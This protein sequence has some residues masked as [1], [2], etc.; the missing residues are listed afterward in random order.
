MKNFLLQ[1]GKRPEGRITVNLPASK[2]ISNRLQI[3]NR[4]SNGS[5]K[6]ENLSDAEDTVLLQKALL[7][8]SGE[9]FMGDAGTAMRFGLA[10]A[11]I[12][13]GERIL[14][15][16]KRL[17][18]RPLRQLAEALQELGADIEYL[19]KEGFPPIRVNGKSLKGGTVNMDASVSSQFISALML[20]APY[21][22]TGLE[23]HLSEKRVSKPYV[24]MTAQLMREAGAEVMISGDSI[25]IPAGEYRPCIIEVEPDWTAA[26]YFYSVVAVNPGMEVFCPG[27]MKENIQG[28][29]VL[30]DLYRGF[31][32]ETVFR[33]SGA[34]LHR[35]GPPDDD[36]TEYDFTRVPDIAQTAAVTAAALQKKFTLLGL[37]TLRLKETDRIWALTSQLVKCGVHSRSVMEALDLEAYSPVPGDGPPRI[38][39]FGD[40]R[41]AMS[42]APFVFRY[43]EL[44]IE[45]PEVVAKSF[46]GFWEEFRKTGVNTLE[47]D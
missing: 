10:W 32:V 43:G 42:F 3:M 18:K 17:N 9:L 7:E 37:D 40:H 13:P 20:V 35:I 8:K 41:M 44:I 23:I 12:T 4:L 34:L 21:L 46:P 19:G 45:N 30:M 6:W 25:G 47:R 33:D 29:S 27:L 5:V 31:G 28:D 38:S 15:G 1:T 26:S 36:F 24:Y 14:R 39:T 11:A 16:S 22:E 2:S